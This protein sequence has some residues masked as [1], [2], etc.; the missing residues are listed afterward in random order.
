MPFKLGS[1]RFSA[2]KVGNS[3]ISK[4]YKAGTQVWSSSYGTA[5]SGGG[6][7]ELYIVSST[8]YCK[9]E[10]PDNTTNIYYVSN[11]GY[12]Y[13]SI[14]GG[15]E[16]KFYA[17]NQNGEH[18][19]SLLVLSFLVGNILSIDVKGCT[20]LNNLRCDSNALAS[21]DVSGLTNLVSLICNNNSL[22]SLNVSGCSSLS[23]L[24]CQNNLLTSLDVSGLTKLSG[25]GSSTFYV[26]GL[27]CYNNMLTSVRA[28]N[29]P[30][31]G[32][33]STF[34]NYYEGGVQL[35]NNNLSAEAL[36]Q[37][38]SDI[39]P[40]PTGIETYPGQVLGMIRVSDNP[41]TVGDDPTIA[42]AKGYTVYG[43]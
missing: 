30:F 42:T 28:V 2:F 12:I 7:I 13:N 27:V 38:Y 4:I 21:L 10:W 16:I 11:D 1:N 18:V 43:S 3:H 6:G 23:V 33:F 39:A 8:G 26:P 14:S 40:L 41:G 22:T 20:E 35:Q 32:I 19:G 29:V 15:G 37:F 31:V 5:V 24:R 36:N 25:V 9:I 17:C 34:Y